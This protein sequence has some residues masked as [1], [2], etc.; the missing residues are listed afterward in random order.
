MRVRNILRLLTF[1]PASGHSKGTEGIFGERRE[2][3]GNGGN[4]EGILWE[5]QGNF[6]GVQARIILIELG[7]TRECKRKLGVRR[8]CKS[9]SGVWREF[10]GN[11]YKIGVFDRCL[12]WFFPTSDLLEI[13]RFLCLVFTYLKLR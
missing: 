10:S 4:F 5:F 6:E 8:E 1:L 3:L 2:F 13:S 7:I 11:F 9:K 12:I